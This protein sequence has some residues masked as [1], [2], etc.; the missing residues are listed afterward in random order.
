[1]SKLSKPVLLTAL[2][3]SAHAYSSGPDQV[4]NSLG[5]TFNKVPAGT[6]TMGSAPDSPGHEADEVQRQVTIS[7]PFTC[8]L[9]P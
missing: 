5:M 9:R 8:R 7:E 4:T 2:L 1:M 3:S 6:F